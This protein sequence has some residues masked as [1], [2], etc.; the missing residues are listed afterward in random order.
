MN[1]KDEK[2]LMEVERPRR[3][4]HLVVGQ[5]GMCSSK[6]E[7]G[8]GLDMGITNIYPIMIM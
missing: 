7:R 3:R 6:C 4:L 1:I 5:R 2:F 8:G